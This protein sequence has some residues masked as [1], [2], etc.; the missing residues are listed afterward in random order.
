MQ[1]QNH[2]ISMHDYLEDF[3]SSVSHFIS[4]YVAIF[5]NQ[6]DAGQR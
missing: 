4:L 6:Y 5:F 3:V 1:W 2:L